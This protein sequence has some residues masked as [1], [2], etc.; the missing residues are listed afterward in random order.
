MLFIA[1]HTNRLDKKGRISVPAPFR[2]ALAAQSATGIVAYQSMGNPCIEACG[3][4]RI[5]KMNAYIETLPPLSEERDALAT[6]V[7]GESVQLPFD[8]EG[9]VM[10]PEHL[11]VAARISAEA[12]FVGKGEIFEIWEPKA[13]AAHAARARELVREKRAG[14]AAP[15]GG[16]V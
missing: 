3:L 11:L 13:Y 2:A 10:L 4:E 5:H 14:F 1:S 7:F 8:T 15:R 16:G 6:V 12:M 9:R